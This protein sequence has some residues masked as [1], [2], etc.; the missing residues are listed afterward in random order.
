MCDGGWREVGRLKR[1]TRLVFPNVMLWA[2]GMA[3]EAL[4]NAGGPGGTVLLRG[5]VGQVTH[6]Y[7]E[8]Q[9]E[10]ELT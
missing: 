5:V 7:R 6:R 4:N 3:V 8:N 9:T 10:I 1:G 2:P